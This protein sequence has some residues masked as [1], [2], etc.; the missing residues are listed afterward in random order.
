MRFIVI[1][2]FSIQCLGQSFGIS[3]VLIFPLP[4]NE[5]DMQFNKWYPHPTEE[6]IY[7]ANYQHSVIGLENIFDE[8]HAMLEENQ[9]GFNDYFQDSSNFHYN[10]KSEPSLKSIH[11][12]IVNKTSTIFRTWKAEDDFLTLLV[13]DSV[14]MLFLGNGSKKEFK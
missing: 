5:S 7:V 6:N 3:P 2:L 8:V 12:T 13:N 10:V 4:E 1:M 9:I 14:C 11:S